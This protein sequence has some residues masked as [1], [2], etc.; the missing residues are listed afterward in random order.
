MLFKKIMN[1]KE[2]VIVYI[3]FIPTVLVYIYLSF[4]SP[5]PTQKTAGLFLIFLTIVYLIGFY[6]I[7]FKKISIKKIILISIF[8][9]VILF[10]SPPNIKSDTTAYIL[11][12]REAFIGKLNPFTTPYIQFKSDLLWSK[13][14]NYVWAN[15]KYT[16]SPLFLLMSGVL[17]LFSSGNFWVNVTL[18]RLLFLFSFNIALF[19]IRKYVNNPKT[20]YLFVLNPIVQYELI[21]EAH[22]EALL[23]LFLSISLYYYF[24][25]KF[26]TSFIWL[27]I[28][29]LIKLNYLIFIPLLLVKVYKSNQHKVFIVL[30]YL[31]FAFLITFILYFPFLNGGNPLTRAYELIFPNSH[32]VISPNLAAVPI[33]IFVSL[34]TRNLFNNYFI[35]TKILFFGGII[36]TLIVY[37]KNFLYKGDE[38]IIHYLKSLSILYFI[39]LFFLINWFFPYYSTVAIFLLSLVYEFKPRNIYF[40]YILSLTLFSSAYHLL[41]K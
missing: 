20:F 4:F 28:T 7:P 24:K 27:F 33:M 32:I 34:H 1:F 37:F 21:K 14:Q 35:S 30:K 11:G 3:C 19:I 5:N 2:K 40:N 10:L 15:Y 9:S 29:S 26:F 6:F 18:F 16:Y 31:A 41:L 22:I 12:S 8:F 39:F 23:I 17:L 38:Q 13:F 25:K 36:L